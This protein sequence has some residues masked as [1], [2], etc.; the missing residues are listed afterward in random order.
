MKV[1]IN[2]ESILRR[3]Q[4][5][6]REL[7]TLKALKAGIQMY[8]NASSFDVNEAADHMIS[9]LTKDMRKITSKVDDLKKMLSREFYNRTDINGYITK[10][11][12][13]L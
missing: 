10:N 11:W 8:R 6:K 3:I 7:F 13:D 4:S 5:Y 1:E 2:D 9:C 12:G